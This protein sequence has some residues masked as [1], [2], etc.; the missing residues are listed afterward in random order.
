MLICIMFS[1]IY[2]LST[3]V[4]LT[5]MFNF[6][7]CNYFRIINISIEQ[8]QQEVM[9]KQQQTPPPPPPPAVY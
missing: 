2:N 4:T 1:P 6:S 9:K 8:L 3:V 5:V 7:K